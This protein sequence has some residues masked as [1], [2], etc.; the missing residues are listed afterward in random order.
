MFGVAGVR[1][2]DIHSQPF[3]QQTHTLL[4]WTWLL[5]SLVCHLKPIKTYIIGCLQTACGVWVC[6]SNCFWKKQ[7]SC[8]R[9]KVKKE[10]EICGCW[11]SMQEKLLFLS[12]WVFSCLSFL[13][14]K[15]IVFW[16]LVFFHAFCSFF[17]MTCLTLK[18]FWSALM[19]K[20]LLWYRGQELLCALCSRT[21][22]NICIL[23]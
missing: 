20:W 10:P 1:W 14:E 16:G 12:V 22:M 17:F 15:L 6:E 8:R 19:T 21:R 11:K 3:C 9:K 23:H 4:Y 7:P 13:P 2:S 18:Y 5:D